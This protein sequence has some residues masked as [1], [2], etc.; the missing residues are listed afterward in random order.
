MFSSSPRKVAVSLSAIL[1]LIVTTFGLFV[2]TRSAHAASS[3][4][5]NGATK[6]QVMDGF[7]FSDA[8]GPAATL[9]TSSA[10][11]QQQIL[12]LLYSP[13]TGAGFTILRNLF[14]S[15]AANTIEPN[16]P[17]SPSATPTY[18]PLGSSEGQV[19]LAQQ[20]QK[21][22]VKQFYGDAW[23]APGYMKTNGNES[24]GGE[25]CGSPGATTCSTGDWRQAY[26][27]YL[28]QYAKDYQAAGVPLTHIGAFNEP[29]LTTSYSSMVMN[30]TQTAD[31]IAVLGPTVKAAGLNTKIVCCDGEGW[32]TAQSYAN[33]I[34]SNPTANSYT[35]VISSHGYTQ[36]PNTDLTGTGSKHI[37][38]TEW[39]KFDNWDPTW[40]SGTDASGFTWAQYIYTGITVANLSAFL[41][42]WGFGFNSTDNG[43]LI[44]DNN[45][46]VIPSK[47]LFAMGSYS[48][49]IHPG[50]TRIGAT[51]GDSNLE[52]TAY[53]NTDGSTSVVVLN[54]S[55]NDIAASLSLQNTNIAA[56]SVATPYITNANDNIAAQAPLPISNGSFS[57][58][59]PARSLVS[60]V[61]APSSGGV[62]P[63]P[64]STSTVTPTVTPT[65]TPTPTPTPVTGS[66]CKISYVIQNQ[67][68]GGFTNSTTITNT[69]STAI[70]S[71]TLKF[72]FLASQQVTQ[73]W[74]GNFSQQGNQVTVQNMSYNG[75]ISP[76]DS[77]SLGFNGSWTGSNPNPTAFTVNGTACSTS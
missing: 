24:N 5:I 38:Q 43:A 70:S 14:P 73:G 26:A 45:G 68:P 23:S 7:G 55:Y 19:W 31:F 66:S 18:V 42:W 44:H 3:I 48:R 60:Y 9:E 75:S 64:T 71:W 41:Y 33:G 1:L 53:T 57:G 58:T 51:S 35:S 34:T 6:Y 32:D 72:T 47:R 10:S 65:H 56:G 76:G 61:I 52:T 22:G 17:A 2:S 46:T 74:N 16:S 36:D 63:T 21:Y 25:L 12:D 54:T 59:I 69:G 8:F 50:A 67:W 37:W 39:S 20:G 77:T 30:P 29:N 28:V 13:T 40:D 27:N 49:F 11:E 62:T 4:T 15:D